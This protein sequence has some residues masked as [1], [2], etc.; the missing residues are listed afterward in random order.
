MI[1]VG[2]L[3]KEQTVARGNCCRGYIWGVHFCWN[4]KESKIVSS[5]SSLVLARLSSSPSQ[6]TS[7]RDSVKFQLLCLIMFEST[8]KTFADYLLDVSFSLI[9]V[10]ASVMMWK[11]IKLLP[12]YPF[13]SPF[14]SVG[15]TFDAVEVR[16]VFQ[17]HSHHISEMVSQSWYLLN[18]FTCNWKANTSFPQNSEAVSI[19]T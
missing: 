11:L 10:V 4:W 6:Q 3:H 17:I 13:C 15:E 16:I 14:S 2:I 18:D 9:N 12:E 5:L 7:C 19:T 8:F 1:S